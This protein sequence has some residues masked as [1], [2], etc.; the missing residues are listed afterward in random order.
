MTLAGIALNATEGGLVNLGTRD[1]YR[2][3][4]FENFVSVYDVTRQVRPGSEVRFHV[5]V[6]SSRAVKLPNGSILVLIE[7]ACLE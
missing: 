3:G 6:E 4:V 2:S 5:T 7:T 1:T